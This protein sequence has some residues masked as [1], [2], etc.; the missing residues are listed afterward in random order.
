M[1]QAT[2]LLFFHYFFN[3]MELYQLILPLYRFNRAPVGFTYSITKQLITRFFME[4]ITNYNYDY[5]SLI[6]NLSMITF[7]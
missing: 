1:M 2:T 7:I 4:L 6:N 5:H 3:H